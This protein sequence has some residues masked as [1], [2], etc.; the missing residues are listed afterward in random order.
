MIRLCVDGYHGDV[1][2]RAYNKRLLAPLPFAGF[3]GMLLGMD[4][5]FDQAGYPQASQQR[6]TFRK[7]GKPEGALRIPE[8][9]MGDEE[10]GRQEGACRTFDVIV[11]SRRQSGWQGLVMD[12]GRTRA[13]AFESELELLECLRGEME[14]YL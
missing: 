2:G 5:L 4:A 3:A 6:R 11:Q 1:S 10:I 8:R 9:M 7:A 12:P 14:A 13:R